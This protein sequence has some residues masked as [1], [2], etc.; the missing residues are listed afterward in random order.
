M[1]IR[2]AMSGTGAVMRRYVCLVLLSFWLS[3]VAAVAGS[4]LFVG[5]KT[6][7]LRATPT[8]FGK[9]LATPRYGESVEKLAAEGA[10]LRVRYGSQEGWLHN[11]LLAGRVEGLSAGQATV[12]SGASSEELALAGKGFNAQVEEA[13]RRNNSHLDFATVDRMEKLVVAQERMTRF[14]NEGGVVPEGGTP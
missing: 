2:M 11:A 3:A 10:W 1:M 4:T 14:L 6:G 8:P 12:D 5:V 13:Y 9:I 7:Q